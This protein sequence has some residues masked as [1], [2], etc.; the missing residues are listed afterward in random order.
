MS[1]AVGPTPGEVAAPAVEEPGAVDPSSRLAAIA[2]AARRL[3]EATL[4]TRRLPG[5]EQL[6]AVR[7]AAAEHAYRGVPL[8]A[9]L[10]AQHAGALR[11]LERVTGAGAGTTR[12]GAVPHRLL[13]SHL[14]QVST[15]TAEAYLREHRATRQAALLRLLLDPGADE[16]ARRSA[17]E[18]AGIRLPA[19]YLVLAPAADP[20]LD[21][22]R[23]G[24]VRAE[25]ARH[26]AEPVLSRLP[27]PTRAGGD[28][29]APHRPAEAAVILLPCP[30]AGADPGAADAAAE[31]GSRVWAWAAGVLEHLSAVTGARL[32]AGAVA[33]A[34]SGVAAAA[35][36]AEEIRAVAAAFDRGP[37]LHRLEDVLLEYQLTRPTP[38]RERLA[39]LL[40]P[41]QA[42]P[43]LL[44]TLRTH[45]ACS[46]HRRDTAARLRVHPNT[47]DYRLRRIA[48][49]TGLDP[50]R[51]ADL[52]RIHAALAALVAPGSAGTPVSVR[53]PPPPPA[54]GCA[55]KPDG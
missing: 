48:E 18:R 53:R 27:A 36:L 25:L 26:S 54:A 52:P 13:L 31:P 16:Q 34:P 32:S 4:R 12:A 1:E 29:G 50:G 45:L 30:R 42:R 28:P 55:H 22:E 49:L 24:R 44:E 6:A 17:A 3:C 37:G 7:E 10:R 19:R 23:L 47:V 43:E 14:E 46:L 41:L 21:E 8:D 5:P 20:P 51:P 33:A 39:A 38:A 35:R 9:V 2:E 15:A 11:G 40:A